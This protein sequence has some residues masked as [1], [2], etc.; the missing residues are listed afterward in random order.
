MSVASSE[1]KHT[2]QE[3]VLIVQIKQE[4]EEMHK[5]LEGEKQMKSLLL[6]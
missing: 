1:Q 2:E 4:L 3:M 5:T 6:K